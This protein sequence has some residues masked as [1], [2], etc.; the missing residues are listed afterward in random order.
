MTSII[1]KRHYLGNEFLSFLVVEGDTDR[2]FYKTFVDETRC[3]ITVAFSK[4][5]VFAVLLI[6]EQNDI[7]GV[8]AIVDADFDVIQGQIPSSP[9]V[10]YTDTHDF[11]TL[12]IKSPALEKVL[13]EFGSENKIEQF[14][15]NVGKD[16]RTVLLECGTPIGYLRWASLQN[17]Y[18][19]KFE[20]L[21]FRKFLDQVNLTIS[22]AK[23]IKAVKDK[24]QRHDIPNDQIKNSLQE[25][26]RG[27]HDLWHLCCGHDLASILSVMLHRAIG[28]NDTGDISP[29]LI[30]RSLRLAYERLHFQQTQLYVSIQRWEEANEPFVILNRE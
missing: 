16:V 24:S 25:L 22:E 28:T 6:L 10:L 5:S 29:V 13:S 1:L 3:N 2:R 23:L 27:D 4:P 21:D 15:Q 17:G 12:I 19:L 9:N 20:G 30:E 26:K 7:H 18:F 14:K 11:E 8:L